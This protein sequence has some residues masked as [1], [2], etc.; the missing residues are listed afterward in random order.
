MLTILD[1]DFFKYRNNV[2]LILFF[3]TCDLLTNRIL[4]PINIRHALDTNNYR[5]VT[6]HLGRYA[7][8]DKTVTNYT[9]G[10]QPHC[11]M[12]NCRRYV[13]LCYVFYKDWAKTHNVLTILNIHSMPAS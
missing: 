3:N 1:L 11:D 6:L 4:H 5:V 8:Y 13:L 2:D 9:V 10:D 12:N 7:E